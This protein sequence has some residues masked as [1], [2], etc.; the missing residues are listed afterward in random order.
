MWHLR[1]RID[2]KVFSTSVIAIS[3][4]C[5]HEYTVISSAKL[6]MLLSKVI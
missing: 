1:V 2:V 4:E 5:L 3:I 6:Q